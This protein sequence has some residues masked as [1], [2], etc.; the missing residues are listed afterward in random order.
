MTRSFFAE[1]DELRWEVRQ[2]AADQTI[3]YFPKVIGKGNVQAAASG[4]TFQV[5]DS[6]GNSIEGPT[7]IVPTAN[8]TGNT[9]RFEIPIAVI[10][11][12]D[13]NY[14]VTLLWVEFGETRIYRDD[15]QFD[16]VLIPWSR[17]A[18]A[19]SLTDMQQLRPFIAKRIE[20]QAKELQISVEARASD[21]AY[22]ARVE[23]DAMIR[24]QVLEDKVRILNTPGTTGLLRDDDGLRPRLIVNQGRLH[25]VEQK[26][27]LKICFEGESKMP[28]SDDE[29]TARLLAYWAERARE[30]FT[31]I[32]PLEYDHSEDGQEDLVIEDIGRSVF[33]RR[34]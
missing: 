18:P 29:E 30:E 9:S 4:H 31:R 22:Q 8:P 12:L 19:I 16:C 24:T 7:A 33:L 25:A 10:S 6:G 15:I 5:F 26:L 34:V 23:L 20:R 11:E 21:I 13:E 2:D 14:R 1:R 17:V 3:T 28:G 32:N 27:A